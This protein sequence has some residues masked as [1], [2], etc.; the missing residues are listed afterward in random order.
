MHDVG[1]HRATALVGAPQLV[2][3]GFVD[4]GH[5]ST[6]VSMLND[7]NLIEREPDGIIIP[8]NGPLFVIGL[9]VVPALAA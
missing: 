8:W 4:K 2:H 3:A 5:G 7:V 6:P 9:A 1:R